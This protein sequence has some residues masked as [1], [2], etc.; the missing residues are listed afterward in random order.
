MLATCAKDGVALRKVADG[1]LMRTL[2]CPGG[3][4]ELR[5]A[6]DSTMLAVS[7]R[8]RV[9]VLRVADGSVL[10]TLPAA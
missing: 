5:F 2:H 8:D 9:L 4:S 6:P 3:A 7:F 10:Y 1:T